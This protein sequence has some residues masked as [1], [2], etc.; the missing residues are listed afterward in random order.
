LIG[1]PTERGFF[2]D[3]ESLRHPY[4]DSTISDAMLY[5]YGF[6][7]PIIA[8]II[9]EIFGHSKLS[10]IGPV[11]IGQH[12]VPS[13]LVNIYFFYIGCLFGSAV[14]Q[15]L[16]DICKYTIGRLRPH[17]FDVCL[18]DFSNINCTDNDGQPFYVTKYKCLGNPSL[19]DFDL[20]ETQDRIKDARVSFVSGHASFSFQVT[21]KYF[22]F[23]V[24]FFWLMSQ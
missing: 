8:I 10:K 23:C 3:D 14:S 21:L 1:K 20:E 17:F 5:A 19:F 12:Q 2:C 9:V 16:T 15:C 11:K 22:G 24:H 18:P 6:S 7:I 4:H 13:L